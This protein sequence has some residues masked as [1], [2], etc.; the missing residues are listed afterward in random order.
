LNGNPASDRALF[1]EEE[2]LN[3]AHPPGVSP[4][5]FPRAVQTYKLTS[6]DR[7]FTP[8]GLSR[9][10]W[11]SQHRSIWPISSSRG[12]SEANHE[13]PRNLQFPRAK[14]LFRDALKPAA[15]Q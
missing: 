6:D 13:W 1:S 11:R 9:E 15:G 12:W 4:D 2:T 8:I 7:G 14:L 3:V 5:A 10:P